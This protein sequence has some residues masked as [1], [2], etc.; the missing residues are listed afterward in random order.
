MFTQPMASSI[1]IKL[2]HY[3]HIKS[4]LSQVRSPVKHAF[5]SITSFYSDNA[6]YQIYPDN[7]CLL[8]LL[9]AEI[10][11]HAYSI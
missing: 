9:D 2:N 6:W 10:H 5:N 3:I 8:V 11:I 1:W 4:V 7:F